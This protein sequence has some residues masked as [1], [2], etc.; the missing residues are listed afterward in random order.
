M[1]KNRNSI[2]SEESD[3]NT[4]FAPKKRSSNVLPSKEEIEA[5]SKT[6]N[7]SSREANSDSKK[8]QKRRHVTGRDIQLNVKVS[9]EVRDKF[10]AIADA[11]EWVLGEVLEY[12]VNALAEKLLKEKTA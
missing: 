1:E 4:E 8:L 3:I 9:K 12:A 2:F 5:V 10:Y 7:F 11:N 6:V